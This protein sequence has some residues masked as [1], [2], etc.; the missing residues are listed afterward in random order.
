MNL[1]LFQVFIYKS[2][3]HIIPPNLASVDEYL[4]LSDALL[5]LVENQEQTQASSEVVNAILNRIGNYPEKHKENTH[6]AIIKLPL[7]IAALLQLQPNFI[8][9]IVDTYCHHDVIDIKA[10]KTLECQDSV[11]V[12]V[13]FT[14]CLYAML[15]HSKLIKHLMYSTEK[16]K[17]ITLGKKIACGFKMIMNRSSDIYS[18][19]E[20]HKFL[21][22]LTDNGYFRGNI[23][24]SQEHKK[25]LEKAKSF[26]SSAES[27]IISNVAG[28]I[29]ETTA[30][31][32]YLKTIDLLKCSS[33]SD[34][35][36]DNEDWLNIDPEQLNNLLNSRYGKKTKFEKNDII[37][38]QNITTELTD[39]LKKTSDY[40]G[41]ESADKERS[42]E[43]IDF[44]SEEFVNCV[45][46]F[47]K[48]LSAGGEEQEIDSDFSEEG[49]SGLEDDADNE[50][51]QELKAKLKG[52]DE[53]L[54]DNKSILQNMISSMREEQASSGPSSNLMTTLG[55]NKTDFLDSDDD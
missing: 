32:K 29:T 25:Q 1:F 39:F 40:E 17:S 3:I 46:K 49:M 43:E 37:T 47:L 50:L 24:G 19:K 33:T 14:K 48:L 44:D 22:S 26:F 21:K 15:M 30:S 9:P 23:E 11:K 2:S 42:N 13:K 4:K 36:E 7:K 27:P 54:K 55:L 51:D 35:V 53:N 41:I 38:P 52:R 34:L 16:D 45:E 5:C 20:Y 18:S 31:D 8:A 12:T 28:N 6:N 10:C